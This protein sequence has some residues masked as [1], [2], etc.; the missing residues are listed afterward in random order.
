MPASQIKYLI[1]NPLRIGQANGGLFSQY[2]G[3]ATSTILF[4]DY[5]LTLADEVCLYLFERLVIPY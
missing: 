3:L 1:S 4:Y 2:Y 5:F